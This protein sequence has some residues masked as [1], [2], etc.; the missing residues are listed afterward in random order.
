MAAAADAAQSVP[1]AKL[2]LGKGNAK[3]APA[4]SGSVEAMK[5]K[6]EAVPAGA[7]G[8]N[9]ANKAKP[10]DVTK[11]EVSAADKAKALA[12]LYGTFTES[13]A[14][15][16]PTTPG[17]G[18]HDDGEL[19]SGD[20]GAV[21][22]RK[23]EDVRQRLFAAANR[24][25]MNHMDALK[26]KEYAS[27]MKYHVAAKEKSVVSGEGGANAEILAEI[28]AQHL[29]AGTQNFLEVLLQQPTFLRTKLF[30][31]P[32]EYSLPLA[33]AILQNYCYVG[34]PKERKITAGTGEIAA[35]L[36][37]CDSSAFPCGTYTREV[38]NL[39]D[40]AERLRVLLSGPDG[41]WD[42]KE[43]KPRTSQKR[44]CSLSKKS[45]M[46]PAVED[47]TGGDTMEATKVAGYLDLQAYLNLEQMRGQRVEL[48]DTPQRAR[49]A[50]FRYAAGIPDGTRKGS[51]A[52]ELESALAEFSS[53]SANVNDRKA[54]DQ[55][56][57]W[58]QP[59]GNPNNALNKPN[60]LV[61]LDE[62]H[63]F[64]YDAPTENLGRGASNQEREDRAEVLQLLQDSPRAGLLAVA[65]QDGGA[66]PGDERLLDLTRACQLTCVA[67]H[68][69][70]GLLFR[71]EQEWRDPV[72][73]RGRDVKPG[74][75]KG[76]S[77]LLLGRGA[78]SEELVQVS[79]LKEPQQMFWAQHAKENQHHSSQSRRDEMTCSV[80]DVEQRTCW[81][82]HDGGADVELPG[83]GR[84]RKGT[85]QSGRPRRTTA[86]GYVS[87]YSKGGEDNRADLVTSTGEV[88]PGAG[89]YPYPQL[90]R[91]HEAWTQLVL[92][93]FKDKISDADNVA[94]LQYLNSVAGPKN[95]KGAGS[96]TTFSSKKQDYSRSHPEMKLVTGDMLHKAFRSRTAT[97]TSKEGTTGR[98]PGRATG[99]SKEG[100]TGRPD[101]RATGT[102][103]DG[104]TGRAI[105]RAAGTS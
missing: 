102:S 60:V 101:G 68:T 1:R 69:F 76:R 96:L 75:L 62:A 98:A 38:E 59:L 86:I 34:A 8:S 73:R 105:G 22:S 35:S 64:L 52:E 44:T 49:R 72:R 45:R 87:A 67:R 40:D 57:K 71:G 31:L 36:D 43:W 61:V 94:A 6:A 42:R 88:A 77:K 95:E 48:L 4:P 12:K 90:G 14:L 16:D 13:G 100:T 84:G 97:G 37:P 11:K 70:E 51:S 41:T 104:P 54:R 39:K 99:T 63:R 15:I 7:A 26:E 21:D 25:S 24:E 74:T 55:M 5:P 85:S 89:A 29:R 30:T 103:K 27:L 9:K 46:Q 56:Q 3:K 58:N 33:R 2:D 83:E 78:E 79:A 47:I 20:S 50:L 91:L 81:S 10:T 66:A 19:A 82:Y 17:A 28:R 18:D 23:A 32:N 93:C 65:P 80:K 92:G 53:R